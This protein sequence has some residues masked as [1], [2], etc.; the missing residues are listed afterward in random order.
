[1]ENIEEKAPNGSIKD[2]GFD[3]EWSRKRKQDVLDL[4]SVQA[5]TY[6]R[7][8]NLIGG[9]LHHNWCKVTMKHVGEFVKN[10]DK[11]QMLDL[12]CG[13]G[14]ITYNVAKR[15]NNVEIDAFDITKEMVD[16]AILRY[17]KEGCGRHIRF[18]VGDAEVSYGS[19]K[20]DL[21]TNCFAFRNFAN[22]KLAVQNVFDALRPGGMYIIQDMTK[23]EKGPFRAMYLFALKRL[24]PIA[25]RI[26]G[27]RAESP[28]YLY[29][30][31]LLMPTNQQITDLLEEVGFRSTGS[32]YLS[33]GMGC[34]ITGYKPNNSLK[35]IQ[36]EDS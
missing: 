14:F 10:K 25:A 7:D 3:S 33:S 15:F 27:I 19:E 34:I 5:K 18:W 21:I 20:Y 32:V 11:V 35:D 1:M 31:V 30:T 29:G 26:I 8:D 22:K 13:T 28:R 12:A 17:E 4:F 2:P 9:M 36:N 23:A 24:L 16:Q 6:D